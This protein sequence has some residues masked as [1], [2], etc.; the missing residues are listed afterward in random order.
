MYRRR[1]Y[2]FYIALFPVRKETERKGHRGKEK[3]ERDMEGRDTEERDRE[4]RDR[5]GPCCH[6]GTVCTVHKIGLQCT[7]FGGFS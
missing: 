3:E 1:I 2:A 5:E 7:R 6:S 4:E